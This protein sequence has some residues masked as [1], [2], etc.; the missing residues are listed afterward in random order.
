MP[1]RFLSE[2]GTI[3][4]R[5]LAKRL[6]IT[7]STDF[8]LK[9]TAELFRDKWKETLSGHGSGRVYTHELRTL[10]LKD[11]RVVV[12]AVAKRQ[13]P[14]KATHVASAEGEPPAIDTRHLRDSIRVVRAEDGW[15]VGSGDI[16]APIL[17]FGVTAGAHP[18]GIT[19][20]P[21]PHARPTLDRMLDGTLTK[22]M[23][24]SL[25]SRAQ[26]RNAL[27]QF[28]GGFIPGSGFG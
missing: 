4:A 11:G 26:R 6:G 27:G 14:K 13:P 24:Q 22:N 15:R 8:A 3:G 28:S 23:A 16:A 10:K 2:N 20:A 12:R 1:T 19:V 5:D 7:A 18:A 21:R 25:R 9:S 17:E